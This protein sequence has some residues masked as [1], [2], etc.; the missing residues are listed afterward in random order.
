MG[1]LALCPSYIPFFAF[2]KP[3]LNV[4]MEY[5]RLYQPGSLYFFTVVTENRQPLLLEHIDRL[6]GAF[7]LAISRYPFEIEAIVVLPEH[8][9]TVWRLPEGDA[10][11]S[12]RWMVI[13]RKFSAGLPTATIN[14]SKISKR[15]KGIWQRRFWEHCIRNE[16]DWR[17]HIDYIHFNPVKHGYVSQPEDWPFSSFQRAVARGWYDSTAL[18]PKEGLDYE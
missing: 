7:R 3:K 18:K 17:K 14:A 8:L 4:H 12:R 16:E 13:K 1:T 6:R 15:E 9:H 11:F 10:D 2:S 5:R